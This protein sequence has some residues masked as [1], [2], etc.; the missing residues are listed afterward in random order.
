MICIG[1]PRHSEYQAQLNCDS[2]LK[3]L[4]SLI[5]PNQNNK[6]YWNQKY[7]N[8]ELKANNLKLLSPFVNEELSKLFNIEMKPKCKYL[9]DN[10]IAFSSLSFEVKI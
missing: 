5:D 9:H 3:S 2:K 8:F 6:W 10:D 7:I 1:N 4:E